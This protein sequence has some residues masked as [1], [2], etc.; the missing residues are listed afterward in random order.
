M[1]KKLALIDLPEDIPEDCQE[2]IPERIAEYIRVVLHVADYVRRRS[3]VGDVTAE[4]VIEQFCVNVRRIL[5]PDFKP[6]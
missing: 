2:I 4:Q 3:D 1:S 5:D 6:N